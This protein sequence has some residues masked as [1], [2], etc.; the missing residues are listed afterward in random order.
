MKLG[1]SDSR[2]RAETFPELRL[3]LDTEIW[4]LICL[5][6]APGSHSFS[7]CGSW[8]QTPHMHVL[9]I[10]LIHFV[11]MI[12]THLN[13]HNPP[14][15]TD[16]QI[17]QQPAALLNAKA[18]A[19]WSVEDEQAIVHYLLKCKAIVVASSRIFGLVWLPW[20]LADPQRG[21]RSHWM[22]AKLS[23]LG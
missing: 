9:H 19:K 17:P 3:C 6:M 1:I 13:S 11:V 4:N 14:N 23:G 20:W 10:C 8:A 15:S 7:P 12:V 21:V 22:Y 16:S 2:C 18:K 5:P